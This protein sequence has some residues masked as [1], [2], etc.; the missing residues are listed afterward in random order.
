[1]SGHNCCKCDFDLGEASDFEFA[2]DDIVCPKCGATN[3]TEMEESYTDDGDESLYWWT[4]GIKEAEVGAMS[5]QC[6]NCKTF[7]E[8]DVTS[9]EVCDE[10]MPRNDKPQT[11]KFGE[12]WSCK[13]HTLVEIEQ[14]LGKTLFYRGKHTETI[15]ATNEQMYRIVAC[16][17]AFAGIADPQ[18]LRNALEAY[19]GTIDSNDPQC[20]HINQQALQTIRA[21]ME[22]K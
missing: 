1:M 16:V 18:N 11:G 21:M 19:L 3:E 20:Q 7:E 5:E 6:E 9:D 2:F 17:N 8:C 4:T 22:G 10:Y 13:G 14:A 12:P 15:N